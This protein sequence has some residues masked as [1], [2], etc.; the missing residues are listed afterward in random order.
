MR[1][2]LIFLSTIATEL[3]ELFTYVQKPADQRSIDQEQILAMRIVRRASD[4]QA[5]REITGP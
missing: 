1:E 2:W 3:Y 4:E 5:K